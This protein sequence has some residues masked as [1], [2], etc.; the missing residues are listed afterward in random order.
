MEPPANN[1]RFSEYAPARLRAHMQPRKSGRSSAFKC[2]RVYDSEAPHDGAPRLQLGECSASDDAVLDPFEE[3]ARP[4]LELVATAACRAWLREVDRWV[5][6]T[7]QTHCTEWFGTPLAPEQV[8][9]THRPILRD[10]EGTFRVKLRSGPKDSGRLTRVYVLDDAMRWTEGTYA[11]IQPHVRLIPI[12]QP[13]VIWFNM[14][15]GL[16]LLATDVLVLPANFPPEQDQD[17]P[18]TS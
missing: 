7:V 12:I 15:F 3:G 1:T 18:A 2:A 11:D 5:E 9:T 16:S 17:H 8:A 13:T 14:H 6:G 10:D 4:C